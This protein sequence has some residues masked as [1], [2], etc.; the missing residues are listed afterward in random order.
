MSTPKLRVYKPP[1]RIAGGTERRP[2]KEPHARSRERRS[3]AVRTLPPSQNRSPPTAPRRPLPGQMAFFGLPAPQRSRGEGV[4]PKERT[5]V[6]GSF[7]K[8]TLTRP[9]HAWTNLLILKDLAL[10][11][12]PSRFAANCVKTLQ[13]VESK[14]LT[15]DTQGRFRPSKTRSHNPVTPVESTTYR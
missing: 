6:S 15:A 9:C 1:S 11:Q 2:Y 4:P 14:G 13:L 7:P 3:R 5:R 12:N 8:G 10:Y